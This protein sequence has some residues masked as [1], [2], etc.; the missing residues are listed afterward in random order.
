LKRGLDVK[1]VSVPAFYKGTDLDLEYRIDLLIQNKVIVEI[2]SIKEIETV[3]HRQ[4]L[5]YLKLTNLKLGI[6]VNFNVSD[7]NK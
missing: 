3:H 4:L 6:L 7:I 1:E 5:I 2:K